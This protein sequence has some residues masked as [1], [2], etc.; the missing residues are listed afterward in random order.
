MV[1]SI[2]L[3]DFDRDEIA[4]SYSI[5]LDEIESLNNDVWTE[6]W[7][8]TT[9]LTELRRISFLCPKLKIFRVFALGSCYHY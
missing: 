6:G 1:G 9:R 3:A 4:S 5:I 7:F 8:I 2:V